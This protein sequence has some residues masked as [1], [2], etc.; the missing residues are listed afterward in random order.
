MSWFSTAAFILKVWLAA[1]VVLG[2]IAI[3]GVAGICTATDIDCSLDS[4]DGQA[5]TDADSQSGSPSADGHPAND[6]GNADEEN[7]NPN[8]QNENSNNSTNTGENGG[9]DNP[10]PIVG[11]DAPVFPDRTHKEW[12]RR[13]EDAFET[14]PGETVA[15]GGYWNVSSTDVERFLASKINDYRDSQGLDRAAY[16]YALASLSRAHSADMFLRDYFSHVSPE[17]D[18]SWH[19]WGHD[20]CREWFS[21]NI[22]LSW[23][24][25][26]VTGEPEPLRTAEGLA[27]A[28]MEGWRNSAPHDEALRDANM[29]AF[30]LGVYLGPIDGEP[31]YKM[32]VSM[33]MCTYNENDH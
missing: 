19:R 5:P 32:L 26:G 16:S 3:G 24:G 15:D 30:G 21:E 13:L 22:F 14:D 23:A 28:T 27:R 8:D 33:T 6:D 29:D 18:H 10:E 7:E 12:D 31:G 20:A 4:S 1:A 25:T 9:D 17:G 2:V 11:S